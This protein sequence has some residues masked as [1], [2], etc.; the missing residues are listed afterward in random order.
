MR[1]FENIVIGWVHQ[2]LVQTAL[3]FCF[4]LFKIHQE[5]VLVADLKTVLGML[6]LRM[7]ENFAVL[8]AISPLNVVD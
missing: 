5:Q 4:K 8:N 7:S 1:A 3:S 6:I 2:M